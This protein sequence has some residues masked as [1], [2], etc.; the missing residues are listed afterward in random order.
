MMADYVMIGGFLGAGKTTAVL[1]LA[2]RL[3]A[4]G[5]RVGLITNDQSVGLVDT[6]LA[7][8]GGFPV[9]EI[10]GGCFC[11]RFTSLTEAADR[12][13]QRA[14]PDV[15]V[16]EPVGSC[17]DLRAS[18]SYP[19][20]RLYGDAYRVAPLSVLIDPVRAA[21]IFGLEEGRSFS[22][23]VRYVY[24]KQLE[25][26]DLIV[27][28]KLDLID[29]TRLGQLRSELQTRFPK[30]EVLAV[31]A[32]HRVG[33]ADWFERIFGTALS[34][35]P[36]PEV[37]YDIYADG[38]ARLGWFNATIAVT[39][40]GMAD[41]AID[42]NRLLGDLAVS[43]QARLAAEHIEIAHCKMTLTPEGFG[44]DLAALNLVRSDAAPELSHRLGDPLATGELLLNLRAEAAPDRLR[45]AV[46]GAIAD[47][48]SNGRATLRT[49]HAEAFSP[50]RPTPTYRMKTA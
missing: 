4:Q 29:D 23:R 50:P 49:V 21:R 5:R 36:S 30:A 43:I 35:R 45:S 6:A 7:V 9:E 17:T 46:L 14:R 8:T 26:A 11:C 38:E 28:N 12:L 13:Q 27:I 41:D 1:S 2:E 40:D 33:L 32:R 20:R 19:L 37:D 15:F 24:E 10:T 25:E 42:G 39:S 31:S 18:V 47:A 48:E 44:T 3:T 34:L 22:P 16:A